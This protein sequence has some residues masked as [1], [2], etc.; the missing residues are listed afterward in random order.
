MRGPL[1]PLLLALLALVLGIPLGINFLLPQLP[2][3]FLV[4]VANLFEG[5]FRSPGVISL[6]ALG[7]LVCMTM[8]LSLQ[9]RVKGLWTLNPS[10]GRR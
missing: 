8:W 7:L 2:K 4:S 10:K 1:T 6:I 3:S 9:R 5:G